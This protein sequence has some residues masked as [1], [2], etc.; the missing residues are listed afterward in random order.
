VHVCS[1]DRLTHYAA[2][3]SRGSQALNAIGIAPQFR[4]TSVHDGLRTYQGYSFTHAWC[5]VHHL[6]ELTFIE[7]EL[8]QV[9][10]HKMKALLL[11]MKAEKERA[12]ALG[13]CELDVL[14]LAQLL[15]RYD[16][17][18]AE[19]YLAN[20]PP[21]PPRKSVKPTV[22]RDGIGALSGG[23]DCPCPS[24]KSHGTHG[25]KAKQDALRVVLA[26]NS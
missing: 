4:G 8:Q 23:A 21:P 20:P 7:E 10:A 17:L 9:W 3:P 15:C 12:Q 14:E 1:T 2:H 6:R 22:T 5:N 24:W 11:D 19:G 18:L 26:T 16:A 13:Q 25:D